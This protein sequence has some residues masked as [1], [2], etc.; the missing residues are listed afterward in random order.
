MRNT[1]GGWYGSTADA[2]PARGFEVVAEQ[3]VR[4]LGGRSIVKHSLELLTAC[5]ELAGVLADDAPDAIVV[6]L[7]L[8]VD[9]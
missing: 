4:T 9:L 3:A 2:R 1:L 6:S 8:S 7:S 5:A